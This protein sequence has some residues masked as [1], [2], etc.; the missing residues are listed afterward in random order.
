FPGVDYPGIIAYAAVDGKVTAER[1]DFQKSVIQTGN[2]E[3][4]N[5]DNEKKILNSDLTYYTAELREEKKEYI[6][7]EEYFSEEIGELSS[8]DCQKGTIEKILKKIIRVY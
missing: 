1:F 8:V 5:K 6:S 3:I 7:L 2:Q 4:W